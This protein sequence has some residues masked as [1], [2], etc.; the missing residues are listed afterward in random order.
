MR[1][2]LAEMLPLILRPGGARATLFLAKASGKPANGPA[3]CQLVISAQAFE[4]S[5]AC[6][7]PVLNCTGVAKHSCVTTPKL[8]YGSKVS[9]AYCYLCLGCWF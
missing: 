4:Q 2:P 1:S 6:S 5:H 9:M 3:Y 8:Q 7:L